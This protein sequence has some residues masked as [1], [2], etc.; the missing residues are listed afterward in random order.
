M[1]SYDRSP[2]DFAHEFRY[3]IR[4]KNLRIEFNL[5]HIHAPEFLFNIIRHILT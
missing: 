3:Y 2:T 1:L 5:G 4:Y